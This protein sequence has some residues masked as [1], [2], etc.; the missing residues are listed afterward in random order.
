MV[1]MFIDTFVVLPL[2]ALVII[3]TL[4]VGDGVLAHGAVEGVTK[5]NMAQLAFSTV[6]GNSFGAGFVAVCLLFFDFSTI[7]SWNLFGRINVKY[8]FW[9]KADKLYSVLA[10]GFLFLGSVLSNDLLWEL[11]DF[12]NNLMVIPNVIALLALGG[13][14]AATAKKAKEKIK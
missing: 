10:M 1:G 6:F 7:I 8:L 13:V 5:T 2:T 3:S 12:F 14:V 9:E 4:Y 11:T